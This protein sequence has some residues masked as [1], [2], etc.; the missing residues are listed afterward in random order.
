MKS[1]SLAYPYI[2]I[3]GNI[4]VGKTTFCRKLQE[5]Y[6]ARLILEQFSEN[7]F[8][9]FFYENP[10]RHAFSVELFF[11]TERHRQLQEELIQGDLFNQQIISDYIFI[12]TLLF[13]KNNLNEEEYRLFNRLF[14]VLNAHF[15]KPDLVVYLHRPVPNLLH[16]IKKRG[17][18]F[19][20]E[21]NATYLE[22]IQK[23]YFDFF[24]MD[25][26]YPILVVGID[27]LDF[28][29]D[30]NAFELLNKLLLQNYEPKVHYINL[31]IT[32]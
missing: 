18:S 6:D 17:R 13:A 16:Q 27:D 32:P 19:E 4:G 26:E 14:H 7:P 24:K 10:E 28:E 29:K 2:V 21:I 22:N 1:E 23:A 3:E 9:P 15:K 30:N 5:K 25:P 31:K 8:L 11:M 12:K 20:M